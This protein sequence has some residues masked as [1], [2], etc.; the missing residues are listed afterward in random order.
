MIE[1]GSA[2][3]GD[4][5]R[6]AP[7]LPVRKRGG[8]EGVVGVLG[9]CRR[10]FACRSAACSDCGDGAGVSGSG[11]GGGGGG[12]RG[13]GGRGGGSNGGGGSGAEARARSLPASEIVAS[14]FP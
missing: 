5:A 10:K 1:E 4:T 14:S 3:S 9:A 12:G 11:G 7:A 13:G 6:A 8:R 2:I